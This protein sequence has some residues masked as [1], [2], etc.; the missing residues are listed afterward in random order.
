[1]PQRI[2]QGHEFGDRLAGRSREREP[3]LFFWQ[4]LLSRRAFA[5]GSA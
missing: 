5:Y 4:V 3:N 1:M 2:L